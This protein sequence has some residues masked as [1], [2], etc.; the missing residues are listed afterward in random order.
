MAAV[1]P[2]INA[3]CESASFTFSPGNTAPPLIPGLPPEFMQ[4]IVNQVTQQAVAMAAA[5]SGGQQATQGS[6]VSAGET[7]PNA[8]QARVV[9]TQPF[10]PMNT[11][12]SV[13]SRGATINVRATV[14]P[15]GG[16]QPVQV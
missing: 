14:P 13:G 16:Q 5:A 15:A 7:A 12:P 8:P 2:V 4:A 9:I 10:S 6:S 11:Q 3:I 1:L